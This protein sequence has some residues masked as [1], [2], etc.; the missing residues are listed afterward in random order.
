LRVS[1]SHGTLL[2]EIA[3]A[4]QKRTDCFSQKGHALNTLERFHVLRGT[5]SLRAIPA[6]ARIPCWEVF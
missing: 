5:V 3:I 4:Q 6:C 2:G 1:Q